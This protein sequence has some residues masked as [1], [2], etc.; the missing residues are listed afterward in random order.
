M[1]DIQQWRRMIQPGRARTPALP[2][3]P[4]EPEGDSNNASPTPSRRGLK[5]K[6]SAYF[7]LV[8]SPGKAQTLDTSTTVLEGDSFMARAPSWI[9]ASIFPKPTAERLIDSVMCRLLSDPYD[10]LDPRFN[11]VLLQIFEEFRLAEDERVNLDARLFEADFKQEKLLH[12][13]QQAQKQWTKERQD[14]KAEIKRLELLLTQGRRGLAEVTLARQDSHL[15]TKQLEL[16]GGRTDDGLETI[17]QVLEHGWRYADKAFSNQRAVLRSRQQSPSVQMRRLSTQLTSQK[18]SLCTDTNV[19]FGTPPTAFSDFL[20]G[21]PPSEGCR[22]DTGLP[23]LSEPKTSLSD[24]TLSTFSCIGDLLPDEAATASNGD[25]A[26]A[27]PVCHAHHAPYT[28]VAPVPSY[29]LDMNV[30]QATPKFL[31]IAKAHSVHASSGSTAQITVTAAPP[32]P[33]L[34]PR[35]SRLRTPTKGLR[36][37]PSLLAMASGFFQ[38]LRPH[39]H[40]D[41]TYTSGSRFSFDSGNETVPSDSATT[42]VR[43]SLEASKLRRSVS[44]SAFP[45]PSETT[46]LDAPSSQSDALPSVYQEQTMLF[47]PSALSTSRRTSRIPTP[48]HNAH[49]AARPRQE[50]EASY[51]SLQTVVKSTTESESEHTREA[52]TVHRLRGC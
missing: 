51:S 1:N 8:S 42:A 12:R 11:G 52:T 47:P 7:T 21:Q 50:R 4:M 34:T 14:L 27:R 3:P 48:I 33:D 49:S 38:R 5:P 6:K 25:I 15:R 10:A 41:T 22:L 40:G 17:F 29:R 18:S 20:L 28:T 45:L 35:R 2:G 19:S 31:D 37:Q 39:P 9:E 36:K 46:A 23:T 43:S 32:T 30:L 24:D 26:F 13:L 16:A 44:L